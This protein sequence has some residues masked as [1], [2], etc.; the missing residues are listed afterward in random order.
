MKK[1]QLKRVFATSLAVALSLSVLAGCGKKEDASANV[2]QVIKY[3]L[4]ADPKTLDPALNSA[5]DGAIVLVNT[6][7]GLMK[8]DEKDK[9]IPGVAE[10]YDVSADGLTYTFHLRDSKWSDGS[11]VTAKDFEYAWL[12]ALDPATAAEYAYQMYYIKNGEAFNTGKAKKEDVGVKAIDDKTLEV[13]LEKPTSYFLSLMAFPTYFPVKQDVV[14]KDKDWAT[15]PETYITNGAFKM[16]EWKPKDSITFVKND[17]YYD[18]KDVSLSEIDYK[19]ISDETSAWA[20]YKAGDLDMTDTVPS[21]E[22]QNAL[23]DKTATNFPN[24]GSYYYHFNV[25]DNAK[26]VNAD[27]AKVLANVKV[28]EALNLAVNRKDIT[29]KVT[30]GGQIPAFSFVPQ[31]ITDANGKDFSSKQY[32]NPEGDVAKAKQLLAEAGYADG[33]GF[34]TLELLYNSEGGHKDIAQ[35]IQDMW[36]KNLGINVELK[37]QEWKVF[38]VTRKQKNYELARGGWLGDYVDPMTFL[39]MWTSDSGQ[40]D[41]G[42]KNADYDALIE[43]AKSETDAAKRSDYM[44]QAE[45]LLMKDLPILPIYYYTAVKGVKDYVKGVRVSPLGFIY[46]DKVT[47]AKH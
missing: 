4:G 39:D 40:N 6:F 12:R 5:V 28:R 43:K 23:A 35:A 42:Y 8:L 38:Q 19:L 3:N 2:P 16:K 18:T 25:S 41:S 36:K 30:K 11:A 27:A 34:P 31:G 46:F 15:K 33:K 45:D 29:E 21:V 9:P 37:N 14:S 20:S 17:N 10:K 1:T 22:V 7:E 13:K 44:H 32:F 47:I 26:N 24:L